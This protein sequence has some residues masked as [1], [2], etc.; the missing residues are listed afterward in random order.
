MAASVNWYAQQ[1]IQQSVTGFLLRP[2]HWNSLGAV[3]RQPALSESLSRG[4]AEALRRWL[5][6]SR[7]WAP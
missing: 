7:S 2:P 6:A 3:L 1:S 4:G 5:E